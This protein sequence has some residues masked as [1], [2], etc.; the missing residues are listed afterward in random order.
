VSRENVEIVARYCRQIAANAAAHWDSPRSYA[1][2]FEDGESD[3]GTRAV[4]DMWHAEIEWINA[5]GERYEGTLNCV[6]YADELVRA[7][8]SYLLTFGEP[9]DL[10]GDQ[11]LTQHTVEMTGASSGAPTHIVIFGVFTLR[12]GLIVKIAE[13]LSR[14]EALK[15]VGL[16]E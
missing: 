7:S 15:A 14:D 6:R 13:Y 10:G 5:L 11:V 12:E 4:L 3:P 16:E 8:Q 2:D 1:R 9:T